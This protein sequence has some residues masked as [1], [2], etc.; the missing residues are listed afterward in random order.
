M[1]EE[2]VDH[3]VVVHQV[4]QTEKA[5]LISQVEREDP[6][7]RDHIQVVAV[8]AVAPAQSSSMVQQ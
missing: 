1:V 7:D 5:K 8:V 4:D 2:V 6:Q 3:Q